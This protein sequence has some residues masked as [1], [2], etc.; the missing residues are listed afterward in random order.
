MPEPRATISIAFRLAAASDL[1][2]CAT[3]FMQSPQM[4][5]QKIWI[6]KSFKP[7]FARH[8][9]AGLSST[10][11]TSACTLN[12]YICGHDYAI[13]NAPFTQES[14]SMLKLNVYIGIVWLLN[15]RSRECKKKKDLTTKIEVFYRC[16]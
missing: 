9:N 4:R 7:I 1:S 14:E 12:L 15:E 2:P 3:A 6:S 5:L 11:F 13:L 16:H 8:R 10:N